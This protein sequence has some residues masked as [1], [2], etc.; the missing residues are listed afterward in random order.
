MIDRILAWSIQ[1]RFILLAFAGILLA[2]GIYAALDLPID[3]VPDVTTNQVQ[4]NAKA[5][6]FTPLEMEQYVTFPI[7]V[8]MSNLPRKEEVRS[9]SQFGLSQVTVVF[10]DDVDIYWARQ[11]ALE[12]LSDVRQQLPEG[13]AP[14]MAPVSTGLGEVVQFV[15]NVDAKAPRAYS[16]MEL[17][18]LLDWFIKPQLRT[19]PGVVEVNSYG[20]EQQQYEVLIDPAKLVS[21]K[22]TLPQVIQALKQNNQNIGGGYLE[23]AGEQQLIRGV[24]L[25]E[26]ISDIENIVVSAEGGTPIYVRSIGQVRRGSQIRQGAATKDGR[27]ETVLGVAMMLKGENSRQVAT[28]VIERLNHLGKALPPGVQIEAFYDR[29]QLVDQTIQTAFRN[30]AEGGLIVVAV[31]FLFL[32][33]VRA[34]LIVSAAIPL[35]MLIAIVGMRYFNVSANLMSLGA[36]DFGLIV[37]AAVIIVEN[38]VRR[39]AERRRSLGRTLTSEER[40]QTILKASV[41]VRKAGQFGEILIIAAY[42]PIVSLVGIEG[43]MFRPMGFTVILALAGALVLSLTLIP[44]LCAIFLKESNPKDAGPGDEERHP[45]DHEENPMVRALQRL[46]RPLLEFTLRHRRWTI[47]ASFAL[48]AVSGF[49][50]MSLGSEF[51][52]K[53]EEGALAINAVRLPG[54]SLPEAIKMTNTLER[55]IHEFPEARTVVTRIGRPEIATDPMGVNAGDTYVLLKPQDQWTSAASREELVGKIEAKLKEL[56]TMNYTFSQPIE[57]RMMELIEGVGSRSDIVIKI[58]GEDLDELRRRAQ[59]VAKALSGVRGAADL[60]V[61]QLTGQP[62]LSIKAN[63]AAI[64]RYGINVADVQQLIQTAIAGTQASTVLEGFKRFDLVARLT[65]EARNSAQAFANLLVSTPTGQKIPLGQLADFRSE[66]G[67]LEVSRENGQRRISIEV[68]VRG[69]DVGSFVADA[70]TAVDK[71][72]RLQPGYLMEWGGLWEHLDSGRARLMVVVPITFVLI[73][74]L[75]FITFHSLRQATLVFTGIP[76]AVTGGVFALLLRGMPFSMSAGVGFIAVSG[77][78]VLNGVVMMSFINHNRDAG[79]SWL[80][81]VRIG[82][83][84]RLRAV[85]MTAAVASLGFLPMALSTTSGAEVQRPLATVVI[86]GLATSTLLTLLVLPTLVLAWQARSMEAPHAQE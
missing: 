65:P 32:L 39:L 7:E 73:Y 71:A 67:P 28:R 42:L 6:S 74:L 31:L 2:A 24:G 12:R 79:M 13:V 30:L 81:A 52:P 66:E 56:P 49:L 47:F 77:V 29:R 20:G 9:I 15:L 36:I 19:V 45:D 26:S 38:C 33:Q 75:L 64:A 53:L 18:T 34:G 69:R 11:L 23:T 76:F 83:V 3:A 22:L 4:I 5:P 48:V 63:R 55:A 72:V 54:V 43:K 27:G 70:Q 40:R 59:E 68:N 37:D 86:G 85:L 16:L 58:F 41:E 21:Y 51:L 35:S 8:A 44:A 61:Q 50:A 80:D 78:A 10:D 84:S 17:R 60:K 62:M 1:Y 25:V 14:E 82:A 57:F 46:Y